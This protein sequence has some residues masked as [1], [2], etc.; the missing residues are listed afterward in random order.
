MKKDYNRYEYYILRP[1]LTAATVLSF[2]YIGL[3][4][5]F[6][7]QDMALTLACL[8]FIPTSFYV[9]SSIESSKGVP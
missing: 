2:L 3:D 9:L 6:G 7:I 4:M 5:V 8:M 1:I